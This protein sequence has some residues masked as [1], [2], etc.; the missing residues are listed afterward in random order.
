MDTDVGEICED[1]SRDWSDASAS[2]A[3]PRTAGLHQTLTKRLIIH[4]PS[5]P[6]EGTNSTNT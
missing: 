3:M 5:E 6:S 1:R 4:S 2:Q